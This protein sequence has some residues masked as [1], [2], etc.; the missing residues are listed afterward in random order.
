MVLD[1]TGLQISRMRNQIPILVPRSR[2]PKFLCVAMSNRVSKA[3]ESVVY[4]V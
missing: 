1:A 2:F 3:V 4:M